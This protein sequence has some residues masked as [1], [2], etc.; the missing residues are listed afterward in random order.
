MSL[1]F[2][3]I[4]FVLLIVALLGAPPMLFAFLLWRGTFRRVNRLEEDVEELRDD[5][6]DSSTRRLPGDPS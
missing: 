5:L 6:S 2:N 3:D 1:A 4:L